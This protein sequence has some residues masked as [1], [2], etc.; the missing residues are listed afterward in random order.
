MKGYQ[1]SFSGMFQTR[2]DGMPSVDRV[3]IPLIQ[4]D[5]AQGRQ[6]DA[7]QVIRHDFLAVL[8]RAVAGGPP[9]DLD[10]VYG[11]VDDGALRPLDGQQRLTTLFLLHWY[12]AARTG[13]LEEASDWLKFS[14]ATRPSAELF[15]RQLVKPEHHPSFG[16]LRPSEWIQ[17]QAWYLYAWHHDPSVQSM[18]VMLDAIDHTFSSEEVD[19]E[20]AWVRITDSTKP[21]ISFHFLPIEDMPSG[22]ELYIKMNSRGKPLTE[23]ET[24]KARFEQILEEALPQERFDELVHKMDGS[25]TDVLWPFHGGDFIVDDEFMR[26]LEF[27]IEICEWRDRVS[28]TGRLLDRAQRVFSKENSNSQRNV[29]FLFH[30]FDTWKS[31]DIHEVF[32]GHFQT[33]DEPRTAAGLR[34][35]LFE[36][37]STNLFEEC[38]RRYGQMNGRARL[39]S[40]AETLL[41][42]AVLIHRQFETDNIQERLRV[43]R[44][45]TDLADEVRENRIVEL[46]GSV[47]PFIRDG[48]I[49]TLVGFNPDRVNDED[50]KRQFLTEHPEQAPVVR[51]L[52]DHPLLRGR[53]YAFELDARNLPQRAVTFETITGREHWPRLTAALLAK[54]DYGHVIAGGRAHQLGSS[55]YSSRWREVLTH[56]ARG[57][58][59]GLRS[60]LA[61]LLDSVAQDGSDPEK[62]LDAVSTRFSES[63]LQERVLDW[64]YY[65]CTYPA[66]REGATGVYYGEHFRA[67]G[68]WDYSM[69]MLRTMSITGGA[70]Y[71]DPYLLAIWRDS[72]VGD[73]VVDPWFR[74]Y[75]HE[76]RWLRL[77]RSDAG[78]RCVTNGFEL[79]APQDEDAVDKF[80][81]VCRRFGATEAGLMPV[82]QVAHGDEL[83]DTEDRVQKCGALVRDLVAAGL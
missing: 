40:L 1:T 17:D 81:E 26:Y 72:G 53:L 59:E 24:F 61:R 69:C 39:F 4:R 13:R 14:Y 33:E 32:A 37:R 54:G 82:Q 11:E 76:P 5:Y 25:W 74:G 18:L 9:V 44:N 41:L 3:E 8:V 38:C 34:V 71:R 51:K 48:V 58:N 78:V 79:T 67:S 64:R 30:A 27:I 6:N 66:M 16:E 2:T 19:L 77:R 22:E 31:T 63:R 46:V 60:A 12:L 21:A 29:D 55:E 56:R 23:F 28:G 70:W 68:R 10:F 47:E 80:W 49:S 45:L 50:N 62:A 73:A 52:E 57:K 36:S 35:T 42:F 7:V 43:L 65:L 15:S 20:S 83:L 75:E